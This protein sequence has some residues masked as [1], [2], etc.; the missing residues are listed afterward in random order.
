M[1]TWLVQLLGTHLVLDYLQ[2]DISNQ[3]IGITKNGDNYFLSSAA[4]NLIS[5]VVTIS[6]LAEDYIKYLNVTAN[7]FYPGQSN[8]SVDKIIEEIGN[9]EKTTHVL[10]AA[11]I[12]L[13]SIIVTRPSL[14]SSNGKLMESEVEMCLRISRSDQRVF[15]AMHFFNEGTWVSLYK[16]YEIIDEDLTSEGVNIIKL[17]WTTKKEKNRFTQTGQSFD[18]IGYE[19]RHAKKTFTPHSNPMTLTEAKSFV[20]FILC[21]WIKRKDGDV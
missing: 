18:S 4:W 15:D 1:E 5:D 3:D 8:I 12:T 16:V 17:A 20:R 2:K 14:N 9:E 11:N 13:G 7:M 10:G 21:K 6:K 19:A